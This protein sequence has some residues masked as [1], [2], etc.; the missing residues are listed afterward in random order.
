[1]MDRFCSF[2]MF[3][4][5]AAAPA[6]TPGAG[7]GVEGNPML[8]MLVPFALIFVVMYLFIISPQRKR[9]K[10]RRSMLDAVEKGDDVVTIGGVHGKVVQ[11]KED[12]LVLKVDDNTKLT[13]SRAA[14]ARV[15]KSKEN[16]A[17]QM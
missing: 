2:V 9:E 16:Q 6:T 5:D 8:R 12:Q 3:A 7:A 15:S 10:Q 13:F 17:A 14:I 11:V 1:M 4:A